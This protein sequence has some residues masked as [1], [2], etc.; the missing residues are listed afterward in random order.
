MKIGLQSNYKLI[1]VLSV[2]FKLYINT[3]ESSYET[4]RKIAIYWIA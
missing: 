3:K 2:I 4:N 1:V